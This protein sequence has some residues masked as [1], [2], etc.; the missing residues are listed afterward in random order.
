MTGKTDAKAAFEEARAIERKQMRDNSEQMRK[1]EKY[2]RHSISSQDKAAI[3]QAMVQTQERMRS[4]EK[5]MKRS[6]LERFNHRWEIMN[7]KE[8][9]PEQAT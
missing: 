6:S 7:R 9:F 4:T 2:R 3:E 1:L 8:K 5:M